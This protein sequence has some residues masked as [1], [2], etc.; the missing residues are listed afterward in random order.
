MNIIKR[1]ENYLQVA[2]EVE[3]F[4]GVVM[5]VHHQKVLLNRGYAMATVDD[6]NEQNTV[7]H[8][9]SIT[10]QFTAAAIMKL[11]EAGKIDLNVTINTYL[12][13]EY[14]SDLW[15]KVT[16][17][18]LLSHTSGIVDYDE[19]YYDPKTI[20]FCS[21][22]VIARIIKEAGQK[23]LE[24]EPATNYHYCNIGYTLLGIILEKQTGQNYSVLIHEYFLMPL[25]MSSTSF[26]EENY[27]VKKDHATGFRWDQ[28]NKKWVE[29]T[30]KILATVPDGGMLTTAEDLYKW[31]TV[32][33]GKRPD[34][35][36]NE[37]I[38]QMVT[39]V[40]NTFIADNGGYGYG[41]AIDNSS[42]TRK[43]HHNG[44]ITGF[45]A[46]F[47]LYPEEEIY[48]AVFCNNTTA[49]PVKITAG[50]SKIIREEL[51][52]SV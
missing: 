41:L 27:V 37:I 32:I 15:E 16:I 34:I 8:V 30:E 36:S 3:H 46:N 14:Q 29:D 47:C 12:P 44:W 13:K 7:F 21:K 26:H 25:V 48:I 9:G 19:K 45:M 5:V 10:K 17:R 28:E 31:S 40:P 6:K 33:A 18:H 38:Q 52:L 24:F 4:S 42:G 11:W 51:S 35:V 22:E 50:L 2:V 39:P 49:D 20:G 1:L 23:K 43:I